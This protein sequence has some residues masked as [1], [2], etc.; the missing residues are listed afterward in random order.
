MDK[1]RSLR[2][3]PVQR[4]PLGAKRPPEVRVNEDSFRR[5]GGRGAQPAACDITPEAPDTG[6][7][8]G[9]ARAGAAPHSAG[10]PAASLTCVVRPQAGG[11][12]GR[13]PGRRDSSA[14]GHQGSSSA[15]R[16]NGG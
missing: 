11:I 8:D 9:R 1:L 5:D 16:D 15:A 6:Q 2:R 3:V 12:Q 14:R 4:H 10:R 13:A 7:R